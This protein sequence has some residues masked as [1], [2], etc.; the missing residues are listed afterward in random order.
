MLTEFHTVILERL[1]TWQCYEMPMVGL[2]LEHSSR[3]LFKWKECARLIYNKACAGVIDVAKH[4]FHEYEIDLG[5]RHP[6]TSNI[7]YEKVNLRTELNKL[8]ID[9]TSVIYVMEV[10]TQNKWF[11][12]GELLI[13]STSI[14]E[15]VK[16]V[17]HI[18]MNSADML[19]E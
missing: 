13:P 17:E 7:E 11:G 3:K 18:I 9:L 14:C 12:S 10:A 16:L 2:Y 19:K 4:L 8:N 5:I 6:K 1:H 15:L